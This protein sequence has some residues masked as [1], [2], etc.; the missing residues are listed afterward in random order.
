MKKPRPL[1]PAVARALAL[2]GQQRQGECPRCGAAPVHQTAILAPHT[3]LS[4]AL[5]CNVDPQRLYYALRMR[6]KTEAT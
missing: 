6:K 2:I 4:A 1:D 5:A 3:A